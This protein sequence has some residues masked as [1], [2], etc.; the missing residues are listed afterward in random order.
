MRT[1][2]YID[3]KSPLTG[4]RVKL[5]EDIE[6]Q[7]FR[8][9]KFLV[10]VRYC[11]CEDTGEQFTMEGQDDFTLNQI[12]CQYRLVHG[13]PFTDEIIALRERYGLNY[14]QMSK[15]LGFGVNQWKQYEQ[16]VVPSE[17]NGK[18]IVTIRSKACMLALLEASRS[19]FQETEFN[20]VHSL[21][22]NASEIAEK[23]SSQ[24]LYYGKTLRG[25]YNGFAPMDARKLQAMVCYL[26]AA[27][28][29]SVCPT[30]LNKEMFYADFLHFR[31]HSHSISGLQY[32]AIQFG[33][34]PEHFDT[35]YDN[36]AGI[37]KESV[38]TLDNESIRLRLTE[39]CDSS[40]L[41][42]EEIAT[43]AHVSRLLRPMRTAEVVEL[44]HA[45][46]AWQNYEQQH[47]FI[48][49]NEAYSLKA[50]F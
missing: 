20:K 31:R 7:E 27:E 44:S 1:E 37:T 11:I 13:I 10:H 41:S 22:M 2:R 47:A 50:M 23:T 8:K 24:Q 42:A 32:R 25:A 5:I 4:G 3:M 43:L 17:S 38:I 36:I 15:I 46:S 21:I 14:T 35:I 26:V 12:Y 28:G 39:E 9:E 33:P 18:I 48:P 34:V 19:E 40:S 30:K 29:G 6:E 45:E 16:G 49:Y